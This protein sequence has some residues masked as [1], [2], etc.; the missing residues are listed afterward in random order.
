[1]NQAMALPRVGHKSDAKHTAD[2]TTLLTIVIVFSIVVPSRFVIPPLGGV[3]R[4]DIIL[5]AG[6]AIW[7][8]FAMSVP[9]LAPTGNNPLRWA[10][11]YRLT[12]VAG[13]LVVAY[14]R[15]LTVLERSGTERALLSA[16][17]SAGIILICSEGI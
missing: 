6:L 12:V 10:L 14:T 1:M 4:P 13:S 7:W 8:L 5:G 11:A 3:G 17:S 15:P 16:I 2:G 9:R